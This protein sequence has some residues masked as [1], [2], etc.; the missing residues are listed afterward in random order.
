MS[1]GLVLGTGGQLGYAWMVAALT[2]WEQA[3]GRDAREADV[4]IGTSAGS[5][6][7]A[8]LASGVPV[9]DMLGQLLDPPPPR[10]RPKSAPPSTARRGLPPMPRVGPGSLRLLGEIARRPRRFPPLAFGAALL[11]TGRGDT[12][13]LH[14]W[15]TKWS[16][17][18][19]PE[20]PQVRIVAMDYDSGARVPFGRAGAPPA[21]MA[22]AATASCAVPG[23][24]SPVRIAGRRYVDGG[25]CSATSAD[26]LLDADLP[27]VDEALVLVPL[28]RSGETTRV[29]SDP[30]AATD[31]WLRGLI[32]GRSTREIERLRE[33][34]IAVTEHA[35][36]AEDR[37]V[38][39]WNVM[40]PRKQAEVAQVALRTTAA[41]WA[42]A[43]DDRAGER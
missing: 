43:D 33:A 13:G 28:A 2:T 32:G 16:S 10:P 7:A 22:E 23:W 18:T 34:G 9:S 40:D 11:P 26:L 29:W 21:S 3:T 24:F 19:W 1:L 17:E 30:V 4:M 31:G 12:T 39:G 35:P 5:V 41:R 20:H 27:R 14:R 8:A 25:V 38:T 36:G 37:A 42:G 15:A 6:V